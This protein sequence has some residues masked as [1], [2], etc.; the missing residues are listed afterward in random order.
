MSASL[1]P[2]EI[3]LSRER[4]A[5]HCVSPFENFTRLH[6]LRGVES[7]RFLDYVGRA[8]GCMHTDL[9]TLKLF[10]EL[11]TEKGRP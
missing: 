11:W 8:G 10:Y 2:L 9:N 7:Q 1:K 5:E 3:K 6:H 4:V